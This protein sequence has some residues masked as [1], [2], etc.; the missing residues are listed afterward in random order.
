[1]KIELQKHYHGWKATVHT[2]SRHV[3]SDGHQSMLGAA[4]AAW[5][6]ARMMERDTA[7]TPRVLP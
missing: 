3:S 4:F 7:K 6:T 5:R 1:M 2:A